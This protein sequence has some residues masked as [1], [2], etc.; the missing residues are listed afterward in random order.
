MTEQPGQFDREIFLRAQVTPKHLVPFAPVGRTSI[1]AWLN[2][3]Q[4]PSK[5]VLEPVLEL[6]TALARAL[7]AGALPVE[8]DLLKP[9]RDRRVQARITQYLA[10]TA[11]AD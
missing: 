11:A 8:G 5:F 10:S 4:R 6:Q 1:S 7:D 9:E 2:G 3:H